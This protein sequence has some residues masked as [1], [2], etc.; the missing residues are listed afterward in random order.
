MKSNR[1]SRL[2]FLQKG[3]K[4][5]LTKITLSVLSGLLFATASL[6]VDDGLIAWWKFDEVGKAFDHVAQIEDSIDGNVEYVE[7]I[8]G[9]CLKT[10]GYTSFIT[11]KATNAPAISDSF[12]VSA[13]VALQ[14]YPWN[15]TA[16]VDQSAEQKTGFFFGINDEGNLGLHL[17]IN[18]KWIEC[19]LSEHLPLLK[20]SHVAAT[21]EAGKGITLYTN[22]WPSS[23]VETKGQFTPAENT[24]LLIAKSHMKNYPAH[25]ER[26][27]SR[28][29]LSDMV[30][31]GLLDELKIFDHALTAKQIKKEFQQI[32]PPTTQPLSWRQLP[33][34]PKNVNKF[35]AFYIKL[36]YSPQWDNLFRNSG[37]DVV[38]TFDS[39]DGRIVCWRGI[40]YN[41]CLVTENG[42]WFSNEFYERRTPLGCGESM[43]DK[44]AKYSHVKILENNDARVVLYWRNSPVDIAYNPP[45]PDDKKLGWGDWSD[46]YWTIYPDGV[47]VR[48]VIMWSSI[49]GQWHEWSQSLPIFQ[50]GQK[51]EDVLDDKNFL[52]LANLTGQSHTY[53]WPPP[54]AKYSQWNFKN[55]EVPNANI[56]IVNYKSKLKPF[57]ILTDKNPRI[58]FATIKNRKQ[59]PRNSKFWWWNHWPV[60]QLPNEGRRTEFPDR[61]SHS[62]TSTQDSE[63]YEITENSM[64]KIML[65]GLTEKE[66]GDLVT[67]A[68]SWCWAPELKILGG[69]FSNNG[70]DQTQKAYLIDCKKPSPLKLELSADEQ[71]PIVNP[72]FV[73]KDWGQWTPALKV[74]GRKVKDFRFGHNYRIDGTDLIVWIK[75]ESTSRIE[76]EFEPVIN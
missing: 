48:K 30:L 10:D 40:S 72:A 57:L 2:I 15:W 55:P 12:T 11:K 49:L 4:M 19:N 54:S 7:G 51:P 37:P 25:T 50:P 53:S 74:N 3:L 71:S 68:R 64:T 52:S 35:G 59:R 1:K 41:P 56:Q 14:T 36:K 20:W 73:I 47:A 32:K 42:N 13:W 22:G 17:C 63:P 67:L 60:A 24:D 27:Q 6:A 46:E 75:I 76:I 9:N 69:K 33:S 44:K 21:F 62:Y 70:Y 28:N 23:F 43:S 38:V 39:F 34:G 66:V 61:P 31:D 5:K 45:N 8:A 65:C 18:G 29:I 26:Q 58:P 16:I